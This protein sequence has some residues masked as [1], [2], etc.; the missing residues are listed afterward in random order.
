[1]LLVAWMFVLFLLT[2]LNTADFLLVYDRQ[3]LLGI[4]SAMKNMVIYNVDRG[5]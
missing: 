3:T 4:R 1:M 2:V 5:G